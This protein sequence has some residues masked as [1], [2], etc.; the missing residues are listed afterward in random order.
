M[1]KEQLVNELHRSARK[2]YVRRKFVQKGVDNTWEID[3]VIMDKY[4]KENN[5][6]KYILTIIDIFSKYA[7]CV[8]MKKKNA[9]DTYSAL[10]S[11]LDGTRKP[12]LIHYDRGKE[13]INSQVQGLLN[14][15]KIKGYS[16]Y[17][18]IKC[19]HIERFNRTLKGRMWKEFSMQGNYNWIKI[20]DKLTKTYNETVHRTIKMAPKDVNDRRIERKLLN[21]VYRSNNNFVDKPNNKFNVG[22]LVRISKYRGIFSKGYNT[23]WSNEVYKI[24]TVNNT[25]PVTYNLV[26]LNNE[27]ILGAFYEPELQKTLCPDV[28]LVEKILKEDKKNKRLYVKY[29]GFEKPEWVAKSNIL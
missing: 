24:Y 11:V 2:N 13:F 12:K 15:Y 14:Q 16:T 25:Q 8:K 21:T 23:K 7:W 1:S 6:H 5:G 18:A 10:K 17:S 3:L 19:P 9:A 4:A 28:Y 27:P 22:T 26:D 20:L 29:I